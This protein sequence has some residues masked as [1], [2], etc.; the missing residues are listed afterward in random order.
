MCP[1]CFLLHLYWF[2]YTFLFNLCCS[3]YPMICCLCF[4]YFL[5][6]CVLVAFIKCIIWLAFYG[7]FYSL[8][9]FFNSYVSNGVPFLFMQWLQYMLIAF[10][11]WFS[12]ISVFFVFYVYWPMIW[13]FTCTM[14]LHLFFGVLMMCIYIPFSIFC[15]FWFWKSPVSN[16]S[17][18]SCQMSCQMP[19]LISF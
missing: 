10:H 19:C 4:I 11:F 13:I 17:R 2:P 7:V 9:S 1:L 16:F 5:P 15:A 14:C 18:M 12:F 6:W 3:I 8:V